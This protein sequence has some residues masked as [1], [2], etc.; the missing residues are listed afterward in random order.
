MATVKEIEANTTE[1][2]EVSARLEQEGAA[3]TIRWAVDRFG[4]EVALACSFQDCVIVDLA[5][6]VD[7]GLEVVFLD[8]GFHFQETLD[9]VELVRDRYQLNL[10]VTH[11]DASTEP[12]PCGTAECCQRRKVEPLFRALEGKA[13]WLTGLKRCDA[14]TRS[15]TPVVAW[16]QARQMVKV[17]PLATWTDDDIARYTAAHDLPVHPLLAKGY[18]SIG[19]APTTRPVK[20]GEDPRAGRWSDSDKTECGLHS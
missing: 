5:V 6:Q 15:R 7:R 20:P 12:W 19:C 8:S 3:E 16:D 1:L 11:P 4:S 10:T 9:F 2:A 17:N 14:P 13:A 18:L